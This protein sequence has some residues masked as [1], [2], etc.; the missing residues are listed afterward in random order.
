MRDAEAEGC[1]IATGVGG[2]TDASKSTDGTA[3]L[4]VLRVRSPI[5]GPT[6]RS[7]KG[8]WTDAEDEILRRAVHEYKG[9]HWKKVGACACRPNPPRPAPRWPTRFALREPLRSH[10]ETAPKTDVII[11]SWRTPH[12]RLFCSLV[13]DTVAHSARISLAQGRLG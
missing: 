9:K 5:S 11:L 6:R 13:F 7:T 1:S 2:S 4:R 8:N 12:E 10:G 3:E